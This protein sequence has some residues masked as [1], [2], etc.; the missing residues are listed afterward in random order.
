MLTVVSD[1]IRDIRAHRD[2][3]IADV[4]AYAK[5]VFGG[6]DPTDISDWD[7]Q[8][9][10]AKGYAGE[11]ANAYREVKGLRTIPFSPTQGRHWRLFEYMVGHFG[12]WIPVT[13]LHEYTGRSHPT[14]YLKGFQLRKHGY[15]IEKETLDGRVHYRIVG[16][17]DNG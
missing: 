5:H 2:A 14:T 12:E 15:D 7:R 17:D 8:W 10:G 3:K 16:V 1:T 4:R 13:T 9:E 6:G 11:I